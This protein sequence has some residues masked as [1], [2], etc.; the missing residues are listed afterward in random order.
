M[1]FIYRSGD[2]P[3]KGYTLKY[4]VG[5]GGFGE[6]YF[7]LSDGGKEVALKLLRVNSEVELR[8]VDSC[9]NMKHPNLVHVYDLKED[10]QGDKW[11]IME[12]VRGESLAQTL[13]R[14][15]RGLTIGLVKEW[16][17]SLARAVAY[18]HDCGVV[19]RDI[20]PANIFIENGTLKV[21]DY[22]LCKRM[23]STD[24]ET[25]N[26]GTVHYMAPEIS[27]GNYK[28]SIDIYACGV[29]LHEMLTGKVPFDGETDGEILM[30]HMT[31]TPD[32]SGVPDAFRPIIAKALDK[33]PL[34][35]YSTVTEMAKA[36]DAAM[37]HVAKPVGASPDT[38]TQ[39]PPG[40]VIASPTEPDSEPEFLP[41]PTRGIPIPTATPVVPVPVAKPVPG[42]TGRDR[43]AGLL[44]AMILAPLVAG[45][46]L[47]P[48]GLLS[49][50]HDWNTLSK[51]LAVATAL[52]WAV[53]I[54]SGT[55]TSRSPDGWGRRLRLGALGMLVGGFAYWLD[56]W[57]SPQWS[58][59][60]RSPD[61]HLFGL[62][63]MDSDSF[64]IGLHYL[65]YFTCVFAAGRWW[66]TA[67]RDRK[68]RI[69]LFP[70]LAGGF[71]A[72]L[73]SFMW[74]WQAGTPIGGVVPI[75]LCA[76]AVQVVSPWSPV[77]VATFS[78]KRRL[79]TA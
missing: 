28:Q 73:F 35:R 47:V 26:V 33:N 52:S 16:F 78:K 59:D 22:G 77:V 50:T 1:K 71:W 45:L 21:G 79:A 63:E 11:L 44:Q 60:P 68:E 20:K 39:V 53:L 12:F 56:G 29:I 42:G 13:N 43:V 41:E 36:V 14:H 54:G 2:R 46:G 75:V 40:V 38:P 62:I 18:L 61:T 4:G 32:L 65:L 3:L 17:G 15:P 72:Y 10:S 58:T 19:H 74:P 25:K 67:A 66:K 51:L 9:L 49:H 24:K 76:M 69:S 64:A 48:Y 31:A 7:A 8:G 30:K 5:K 70:I 23:S 55:A 57:T 6:V 34:R 27:T 37:L